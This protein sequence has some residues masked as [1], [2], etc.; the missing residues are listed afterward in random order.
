MPTIGY[1]HKIKNDKELEIFNKGA[2][3]EYV[4]KLLTSDL[5]LANRHVNTYIKNKYKVNLNLT[6]KQRE[7]LIDFAFNLGGLEKFPKLTDAVLRNN[8]EV[9]KQEYIRSSK[10]K[11]LTDRNTAFYN[12]F[13][14]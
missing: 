6:E 11:P 3:D 4:I 8:W 13:L 14:K 10:G 9:V 1:G 5:E 7:I 12:R 2:S